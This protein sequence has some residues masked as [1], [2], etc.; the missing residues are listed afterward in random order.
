MTT[1]EKAARWLASQPDIATGLSYA[2]KQLLQEGGHQDVVSARIDRL[3]NQVRWGRATAGLIGGVLFV[4]G[5]F[6]WAMGFGLI[7]SGAADPTQSRGLGTLLVI[8]A[9]AIFTMFRVSALQESVTLFDGARKLD[10]FEE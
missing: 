5:L 9:A 10:A 2:D 6:S 8:G 4:A 1:T 7:D 3:R